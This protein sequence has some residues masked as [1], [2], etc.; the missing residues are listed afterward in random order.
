MRNFLKRAL[1]EEA[2]ASLEVANVGVEGINI[3]LDGRDTRSKEIRGKSSGANR[4]A[5]KTAAGG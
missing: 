2:E 3:A 5:Q 4:V 1:G